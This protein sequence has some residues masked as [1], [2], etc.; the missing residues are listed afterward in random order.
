[1]SWQEKAKKLAEGKWIRFSAEQPLI[2]ITFCGEP[3]EV[4]KTVQQG[5]RKGETYIQMSFPV[6]VDEADR[7]L[8]P[9]KSLLRQIV[10]EDEIESIIGRTVLIKCL[11]L[12]SMREWSI[13]P[14][15]KQADVTRTWAGE[16]KDKDKAKFMEG[17]EQ[18]KKKRTRK[19][20]TMPE[21]V[22]NVENDQSE[23]QADGEQES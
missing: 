19:P 17:V 9:N 11:D 8:E 6:R 7:I 22:P 12:K 20:K 2:E 4:T 15:G 14:M 18:Q 13:R 10:A 16:D 21:E 3:N 5:D 1:M 23:N